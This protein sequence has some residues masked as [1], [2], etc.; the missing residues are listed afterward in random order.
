MRNFRHAWHSVKP[1]IRRATRPLPILGDLPEDWADWK[2]DFK[3]VF[4]VAFF[5]LM[6]LW[7]GLLL[8]AVVTVSDGSDSFLSKFASSSDLG[9]LSASLLG[10]SLYMMFR[11]Q[12]ETAGVGVTPRFPSGL[13]FIITIIARVV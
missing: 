3:E 11:E 1:R 5:S 12:S 9:I 13:W 6:P 7:L 8:V 10:P 2:E 4:I